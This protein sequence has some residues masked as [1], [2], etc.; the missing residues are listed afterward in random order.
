MTFR[1]VARGSGDLKTR[2][3]PQRFAEI[4]PSFAVEWL[5]GAANNAN[6]SN[7]LLFVGQSGV[8]KTTA[9]RV[10]ARSSVCKS[11]ADGEPCLKCSA[12]HQMEKSPDYHEINIADFRKID[13]VREFVQGFQYRPMYLARKVYI[14]DECHQLTQ[15]AQ[16][17]LLK[18]LEEAPDHLLIVLCTTETR[19]LKRTLLS[20]C[21]EI[22]FRPADRSTLGSI[23]VQIL[24][25]TGFAASETALE[26]VYQRAN[27]SIREF[28]NHLDALIAGAYAPALPEDEA[29]DDVRDLAAALMARNWSLV[30][31]VLARETVKQAPESI[32]LMTM[33]Y[34][35]GMVLRQP[36]LDFSAA[37]PMG[38]LGGSLVMEPKAEQ[39]NLLVLRCMRACS[40]KK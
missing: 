26:D 33:C 38:Q 18:H 37:V 2:Y 12:C 7:V 22:Q 15:D 30:R 17:V 34:L 1:L 31:G 28:L 8:G 9:A 13:D 35:R 6:T 19:G 24:E 14:L 40:R 11:P 5:K 4:A 32:R 36:K 20:R 10:L 29:T 27:G 16:Q 3:R 23:A 21:A 25:D 39:Y